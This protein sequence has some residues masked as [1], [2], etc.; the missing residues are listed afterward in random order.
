MLHGGAHTNVLVCVPVHSCGDQSRCLCP[1]LFEV[2]S[3]HG[4]SCP[5]DAG[6]FREAGQVTGI[7]CLH[8]SAG[9]ISTH[10]PLL[11]GCFGS[12]T[13]PQ[14]CRAGTLIHFTVSLP[15]MFTQCCRQPHL[16][17]MDVGPISSSKLEFGYY[18]VDKIESK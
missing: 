18:L 1:S 16:I 11:T 6:C 4:V 15:I 12:D 10:G 5:T 17:T 8:P 9:I 14:A 3:W 7:P 2:L 13:G